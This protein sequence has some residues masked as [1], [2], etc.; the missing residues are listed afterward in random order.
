MCSMEILLYVCKS[1]PQLPK[2][3]GW[4]IGKIYN[5]SVALNKILFS[6]HSFFNLSWTMYE[7]HLKHVV[8]PTLK[9][10]G[11]GGETGPKNHAYIYFPACTSCSWQCKHSSPKQIYVHNFQTMVK[12][13]MSWVWTL[14]TS[15]NSSS[16]LSSLPNSFLLSSVVGFTWFHVI[17]TLVLPLR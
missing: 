17:F 3:W 16:S 9:N 2:A 13:F 12:W 14:H 8:I 7:G 5:Y 11:G 6:A 15:S 4:K 1:I 10:W